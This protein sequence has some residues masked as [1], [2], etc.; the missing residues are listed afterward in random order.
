MEALL[1]LGVFVI[2]LVLGYAIGSAPFDSQID[3]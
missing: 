3:P 1:I 2:G